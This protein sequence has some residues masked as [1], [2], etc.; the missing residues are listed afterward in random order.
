MRAIA[1]DVGVTA[2]AL[3][4]YAPSKAALLQ[5]VFDETMTEVY[6]SLEEAVAGKESMVAEVRAVLERSGEILQHDPDLLQFLI[7]VVLDRQPDEPNHVELFAPPIV[8]FFDALIER[9]VSRGELARRD[10]PRLATFVMMLL[11]GVIA[12]AA[13]DPRNIKHA[14]ETAKWAASGRLEQTLH[15]SGIRL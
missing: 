8:A 9:A 12:L 5:L 10:G 4:T 14:V 13:S 7:R 2:M 11:W 3:Y 15:T 1:A 6:G